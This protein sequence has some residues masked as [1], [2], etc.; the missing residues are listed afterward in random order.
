[1]SAPK[2]TNDAFA[3]LG[4]IWTYTITVTT[5]NLSH[6]PYIIVQIKEDGSAEQIGREFWGSRGRSLPSQPSSHTSGTK[7]AKS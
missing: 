2:T 6:P 7:A 5:G 3:L 1:M 4:L